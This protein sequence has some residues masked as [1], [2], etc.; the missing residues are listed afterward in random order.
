MFCE[1]LDVVHF[2]CLYL[3][4]GCTAIKSWL[5]LCAME[6]NKITAKCGPVGCNN[7]GL[8]YNFLFLHVDG[9][10][11]FCFFASKI[12]FDASLFYIFLLLTNRLHYWY[13]VKITYGQR[14]WEIEAFWIVLSTRGY[15][16][17]QDVS[18]I[19]TAI[20]PFTFGDTNHVY[21]LLFFNLII[22]IKCL[23]QVLVFVY[24][25]L[26]YFVKCLL[27]FLSLVWQDT[28]K[29]MTKN[30]NEW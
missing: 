28:C 19:F 2:A 11:I 7:D 6:E 15:W 14:D 24:H 25:S 30:N 18:S 27:S 20:F 13:R 10:S 3:L 21:I 23:N 5:P 17:S 16:S 22:Y 9:V 1:S 8:L 4:L 29:N 12:S 26:S